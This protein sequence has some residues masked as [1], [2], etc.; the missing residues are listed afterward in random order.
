MRKEGVGPGLE[1]RAAIGQQTRGIAPLNHASRFG[2]A[3][4][5]RLNRGIPCPSLFTLRASKWSVTPEVAGSSP[6]APVSLFCLQKSLLSCLRWL[7][8]CMCG[9][10]TGS[11]V[12]GGANR[13]FLQI[14]I[15][16]RSYVSQTPRGV[17]MVSV[18]A[19]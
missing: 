17:V 18:Q 6:V 12:S 8:S 14:R 11:T 3:R 10:Q 15:S 16:L 7:A 19:T 9:Q 4:K 5:S 1:M 2:T 13:K